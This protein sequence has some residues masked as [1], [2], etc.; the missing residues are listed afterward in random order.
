MVKNIFVVF[1]CFTLLFVAFNP[2]SEPSIYDTYDGYRQFYFSNFPDK[3]YGIDDIWL[4]N[5]D[6][7]LCTSDIKNGVYNTKDWKYLKQDLIDS[8]PAY[9]FFYYNYEVEP[10]F[11]Y[12]SQAD[13]KIEFWYQSSDPSLAWITTSDKL[14]HN[15]DRWFNVR[16][17]IDYEW[18][19]D[20]W[21]ET[22]F[23]FSDSA[24]SF[25]DIF[26]FGYELTIGTFDVV[27]SVFKG[28]DAFFDR[29][30]QWKTTI[31]GDVTVF[32]FLTTIVERSVDFLDSIVLKI[33][34]VREIKEVIDSILLPFKNIIR[35]VVDWID[36]KMG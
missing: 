31:F 26:A 9:D 25:D 34:V 29:F 11:D 35:D 4:D 15:G 13:G 30:D 28:P 7:Y 36:E 33:P 10:Y 18:Y 17:K 22:P 8:V 21:S 1:L 24:L 16:T 6:L 27:T 20:H 2:D 32:G 3:N 19:E 5:G 14:L 12:R 23:V